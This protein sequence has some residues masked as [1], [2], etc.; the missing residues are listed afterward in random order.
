MGRLMRRNPHQLAELLRREVLLFP[1]P[2]CYGARTGRRVCIL[3]LFF[4][5]ASNQLGR[6]V[7]SYDNSHA[8]EYFEGGD[9]ARIASSACPRQS[10]R[11]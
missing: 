5:R 11:I 2:D 9:P 10:P 1:P 6:Q 7:S 4:E 3:V 8:S